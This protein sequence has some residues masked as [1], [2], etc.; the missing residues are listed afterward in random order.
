MERRWCLQTHLG[1]VVDCHVEP[2]NPT[3]LKVTPV[4]NAGWDVPPSH[5]YFRSTQTI[6]NQQPSIYIADWMVAVN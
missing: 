5:S 4:P 6:P 2:N 3:P 1:E